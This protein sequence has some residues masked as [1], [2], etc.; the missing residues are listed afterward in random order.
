MILIENLLVQYGDQIVL[1]VPNLKID[2]NEKI[3]IIGNSGSGKTTLLECLFGLLNYKGKIEIDT[4]E[5][6]YAPQKLDVIPSFTVKT[7]V[8]M[9]RFGQHSALMNMISILKGNNEVTEILEALNIAQHKSKVVHSLSGG[10]KQR[11]LIARTLFENK[12]INLFD[13]PTSAL[14]VYNSQNAISYIMQ[15]GFQ[16]TIICSIHDLSLIEQFE[17]VIILKNGRI[18]LDQKVKEIEKE[19]LIEYFDE[20]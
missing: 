7:N 1:S 2:S 20:E 8:Q 9:G 11:V 14:D 15:R 17:R 6:S 19:R 4:T 18:T 5:I 16:K 12:K 3:C 10:E 13:E